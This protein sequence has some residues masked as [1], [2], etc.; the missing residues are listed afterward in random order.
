VLLSLKDGALLSSASVGTDP[1]A[2]IVADDGKTAYVADSA[3]GDVYAVRLPGLRV[4]WKQHVGGA[5]FGLLLHQGRLFASL[6]DGASVV[7]LEPSTGMV[8]ASHAVPP[9]PAA[10]TVDGAGNVVVAGTRGQLSIIGGGQLAAGNG[11]GVAYA[12]GRLWSAD[13]ERAELVPAGDDHRVGMPAPVF[14]FWLA[15]G[16]AG[17]LLIAAE[18]APEDTAAGGVFSF[19]TAT[20]VIK[21]LAT[22]KDP[23]Q[24][25]QSGSTV[26]AAAHGEHDVLAIRDGK[27]SAWAQ[28]IEAVGLAADPQLSMLVVVVNAHE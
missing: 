1:V 7:E 20:G 16:P 25:L 11:F 27:A 2:V 26:F 14:P 5:P 24:V 3:P 15:A 10:M 4:G 13:Y 17:T 23:D 9:G 21:T 18:G 22:P 12:G 28:G 6:F 19:D 8:V